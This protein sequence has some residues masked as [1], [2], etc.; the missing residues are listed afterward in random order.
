MKAPHETKLSGTKE[1][2]P[3]DAS[4]R[5]VQLESSAQLLFTWKNDFCMIFNFC[6]SVF[7]AIFSV[8]KILLLELW[9]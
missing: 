3:L 4:T 5:P 9:P 1:I 8:K 2:P 7:C 6:I